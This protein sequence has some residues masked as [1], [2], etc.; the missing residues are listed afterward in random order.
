MVKW[1][2]N[3][4][5]SFFVI[6]LTLIIKSLFNIQVTNY[7]YW[8]ALAQG[9]HKFFVSL[10]GERGKI[11][12]KDDLVAATNRNIDLVY[13]SPLEV[14]DSEKTA[15]ALHFVLGIPKEKIL[16]KIKKDN[17]YEILK[18]DLTPEEVESIKNLNLTGVYLGRESKR[19]YP[20]E[21]I[22]SRVIGFLGG[23]NEG[24]YGIEGFYN[25]IL[26][27][28]K[29][30]LEKEKG[31]RGYFIKGFK[32]SSQKEKDIFLTIDY[33]IQ[34]T[35]EKLLEDAKENFDIEKGE[36]IIADPNSGKILALANFP[37]FN[38]NKY[39]ENKNLEIFRNS[40]IQELFEPGSVFK[41]I[42]MAAA[43]DQKKINP[44][45][46]YYDNG[47]VKIGNYIINNYANK[48]WGERTMT[49]VLEKSINTGAIFA[50][51]QI[52]GQVFL[53]YIDK[54]GFFSPT[55]IDLQGEIFS[56]NKEL[57]KSYEVNLATASFGQGVEVTS[58]Q[59]IRAFSAIANG[60]NLIK[61]F[62]V[63]KI[64]D[65]EKVIQ[66]NTEIQNSSIISKETS[67]QLISMMV[68][69]I[70]KG[71]SGNGK[72]PGY[73]VAGKTGTAQI[74]YE[75]KKGYYPDKTI[76]SFIGFAPAYDAKFVI[77]V[78]LYNPKTK[79][80]GYSALPIFKKLSQYLINYWKIP[81]DYD[82]DTYDSELKN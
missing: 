26:R 41:V 14:K 57:K 24:Q 52:G 64:I 16:E 39:S 60:G 10:E 66:N 20:Y 9:Q 25:E 32:K 43:I 71:F 21:T 73:Y 29:D 56:Q 4:I 50:Q 79:T 5:L 30:L 37:N 1:R 40:S 23:D 62:L 69:V 75:N 68:S 80:A 59:L 22:A 78:K 31:P 54:F 15:E 28:K 36:I 27:G 47:F 7:Q 19:F 48:V 6:F 67:S 45:T 46:T 55:K 44:Q 8:K 81:P 38:P 2:V 76:Q 63:E 13:L 34:F 61:P 33:N 58:I 12:F 65:G 49:E 77:L 53:D 51:K 70:E 72:I 35:A 17:S 74:P 82:S 18:K 11:F 42:T 3:L